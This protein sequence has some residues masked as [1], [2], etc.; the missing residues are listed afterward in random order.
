MNKIDKYLLDESLEINIDNSIGESTFAKDIINLSDEVLDK[1]YAI[2]RKLL[3]EKRYKEA[4]KAYTF[5]TFLTPLHSSFWLGLGIAEQSQE[6]YNEALAAYMM[7]I[8]TN[9]DNL[10]PY[11]NCAQCCIALNENSTAKR[12]CEKA[13]EL[14]SIEEGDDLI[15]NQ[16][17]AILLKELK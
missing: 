10:A 1:Y 12:L 2:S 3:S 11:A 8:E 5:L 7:A 16:I 17:K 13:L 14:P 4:A 9:P 6:D 15:K